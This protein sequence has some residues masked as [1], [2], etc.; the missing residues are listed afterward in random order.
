MSL[1]EPADETAGNFLESR[2]AAIVLL[3]SCLCCPGEPC[4]L[5]CS[6]ITLLRVSALKLMKGASRYPSPGGCKTMHPMHASP[7]ELP[8][9]PTHAFTR[10]RGHSICGRCCQWLLQ[11]PH[12]LQASRKGGCRLR[13]S[14]LLPN[15]WK[16]GLHM[17]WGSRALPC[18]ATALATNPQGGLLLLLLAMALPSDEGRLACSSKRTAQGHLICM[19]PSLPQRWLPLLP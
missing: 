2:H 6:T 10:L 18:T 14:L 3:A 15:R 7:S 1:L 12:L 11:C 16:Q 17:A 9:Y 5:I 13:I 8:M 4:L 19:P